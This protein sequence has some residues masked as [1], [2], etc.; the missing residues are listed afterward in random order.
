MEWQRRQ[1]LGSAIVV[2]GSIGRAAPEE[3][4]PM[5]GLIVKMVAAAGKREELISVLLEGT[6]A[7][8][9]CLSYVIARDSADADGIWITEVWEDKASHEASLSLPVVQKTIAA[10]RPMIAAFNNPVSRRRWAG[11]ACLSQS[12]RVNSPGGTS[13]TR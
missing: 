9:G 7:M 11:M 12:T 13:T 1:I 3:K 2:L 4:R 5:F 10:A 8:P 6:D